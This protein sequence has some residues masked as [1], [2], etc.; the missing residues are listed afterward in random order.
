[1]YTKRHQIQHSEI[2]IIKY[3]HTNTYTQA[4]DALVF[5]F[6]ARLNNIGWVLSIHFSALLFYH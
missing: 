2:Y 3:V 6:I 4:L 5:V 1:M